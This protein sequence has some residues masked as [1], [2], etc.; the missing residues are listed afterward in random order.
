MKWSDLRRKH[1]PE[2]EERIRQKVAAK[3]MM[4]NQLPEARQ[5][6]RVLAEA[7]ADADADP[8]QLTTATLAL[9]EAQH[10]LG[11]MSDADYQKIVRGHAKMVRAMK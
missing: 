10:R 5:L 3:G 1:A 4:L 8:R 11:I 7:T 9:A 2:V 6:T